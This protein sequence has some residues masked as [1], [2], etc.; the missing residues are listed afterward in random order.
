MINQPGFY[1]STRRN[2]ALVDAIIVLLNRVFGIQV[3]A[4]ENHPFAFSE[5]EVLKK[6]FG[7]FDLV[8]V[9][10]ERMSDSY[11][12][13]TGLENVIHD[14]EDSVVHPPTSLSASNMRAS[15]KTQIT[16]KKLEMDPTVLENVKIYILKMP[17]TLA[18]LL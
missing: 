12:V 15:A 10:P 16:E 17:Q 13:K 1:V 6:K 14:P 8:Y 11:V 2:S 4:D 3:I 5:V 9:V 18:T 7:T